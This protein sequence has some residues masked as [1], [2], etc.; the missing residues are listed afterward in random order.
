MVLHPLPVSDGPSPF[1]G[2][3]G[4]PGVASREASSLARPRPGERSGSVSGRSSAAREHASVS[5]A[6]LGA[7]E[8]EVARSQWTPPALT[9]SS[10]ASPR[11]S[12]HALRRGESGES[13]VV[14]SRS[15]SSCVS[16][17]SDEEQGRIA[18]PALGR[19]ALVI[20]PVVLALVLLTARGQEHRRRESSRSLSSRE[21]SRR[22]RS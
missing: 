20:A 18:E 5:S 9:A 10:V 7:A 19:T 13:S 11:S 8:G 2:V 1:S 17:S 21:R 22:D 6:P 4:A 16:R 15:R 3:G 12:Q 14:R